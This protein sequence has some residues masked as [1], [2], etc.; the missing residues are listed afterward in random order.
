M[1]SEELR[2]RFFEFFEQRGHKIVPSSSLMPDD[3][4]VLL[5]TAGMQ[6]F[7]AYFLDKADPVKDFGSKKVVSIQ[8]CFRTSDIDEV[9]DETHLTFFEMLGH[10]SFGDYFKRETIN[11]TF[12]LLTKIFGI[13][14]ERI[15]ATVFEGDINVPFDKES[16]E[17]WSKLL[18]KEQIGKE[19]RESNFWGP[20]GVEG[21]CGA[22]NEVYVDGIEVATLVFIEYY[23]QADKKLKPLTEKG[24][25]VG[26]G[27]ERLTAILQ[28]KK[29]IF[30]TDLFQPLYSRF[31]V[32]LSERKRRILA[33]HARAVAFLISDGIRPSNKEAGYVLRRLMRRIIVYR[34]N[35]EEA[36]F[37]SVLEKYNLFYPELDLSVITDVFKE[38]NKKFGM[39]LEMGLKELNKLA[40][41]NAQ[42]AFK[43]YESFGLPYEA[44]KEV[45][46]EKAKNL[47]WSDFDKEFQKHQKISRAGVEKKFG[48]HGLRLDTGELKAADETEIKKVMRLHTATH[49]LH[50][51]LREV[52]G[53]EIK[54]MGSDVT[55]E[56]TRFDFSFPRKLTINEIKQVE[57]IVNQKI[58]ADLPV[59]FKEMPQNEAEKTGAL[60][61]FKAKYPPV[62]KVYFVGSDLNSAYSKEFCGGPH[63]SR[64]SEIGKFRIIKE[65]GISA[66]VRRIRAVVE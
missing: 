61:F 24:V 51:A 64:T 13:N 1:S 60:H 40:T 2:K 7:K 55:A 36:L 31:P 49:L 29:S 43:L 6:Q 9:G 5:T 56:R 14:S 52:L 48:G 46:G 22:C 47:T 54:Q 23:S 3:P 38:E 21:P 50:Q 12:E 62:V 19:P 65:E 8:K 26:W 17:I 20:T 66:G 27:F 37:V 28:E 35:V 32:N 10:F 57:E 39:T 15:S 45:G 58:E 63:V 4:S 42:T 16:F 53:K 18:L 44:I 33:D 11:W 41:V 25:D 59:S 30:E 34:T